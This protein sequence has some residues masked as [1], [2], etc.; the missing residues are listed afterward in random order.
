MLDER[1]RRLVEAAELFADGHMPPP[2]WTELSIE[3]ERAYRESEQAADESKRRMLQEGVG[4]VGSEA[5]CHAAAAARYLGEFRYSRTDLDLECVSSAVANALRYERGRE[6]G[7][8]LRYAGEVDEHAEPMRAA[9]LA[10]KARQVPL[11]NC[12]F[13]NPFRP[14][15]FDARW[16]TSDV[17]GLAQAIYDD[18]AFERMPILGDALMDAGC[19]DEQIIGHCRGDGPHVRGCWVVDLVLG[20]E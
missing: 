18:K 11:V 20:R 13:G 6:L 8:R 1:S 14:V 3:G 19:E 15:T 7:A 5:A 16:R 2:E 4:D 12:V 9:S 10:E 17:V